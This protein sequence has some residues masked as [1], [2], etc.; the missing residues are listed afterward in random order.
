MALQIPSQKQPGPDSFPTQPDAVRDWVSTLYPLTSMD[1]CRALFRGL[2]HSNRLETDNASRVEIATILEPAIEDAIAVLREEFLDLSLPFPL[3]AA[4]AR[5]LALDLLL[6]QT[7]TYKIIVSETNNDSAQTPGPSR[8]LAIYQAL[9]T[10]SKLYECHLLSHSEPDPILLHDANTLF[11]E[12]GEDDLIDQTL[13]SEAPD[14]VTAWSILNAYVYLQL[15]SLSCPYDQR[16]RQLPTLFQFLTEHTPKLTVK[17]YKAAE[18]N[19]DSVYA[20]H[21]TQA[22]RPQRLKHTARDTDANLLTLDVAPLLAALDQVAERAPETINT[23]YEGETLSRSGLILLREALDRQKTRRVARAITRKTVHTEISL[24]HVSAAIRFTTVSEADAIPAEATQLSDSW[25][26]VPIHRK[27]RW[28]V[29]NEN[30]FGACLEWLDK[31]PTDAAVGQV[32]ALK[33]T[34]KAKV[35][36]WVTGIIRWIKSLGPAHLKIGIEF[37][38]TEASALKVELTTE[39]QTT[40]H[41]CVRTLLLTGV[42]QSDARVALITPP[43]IFR[44][45]EEI[46]TE[47]KPLLLEERLASTGGFDVFGVVDK[48]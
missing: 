38:G 41:D 1:S 30:R 23:F 29:C 39:E 27:G 8:Q 24:R 9:R 32:I 15:L 2:K 7:F 21:H 25:P 44:Q 20:I 28:I 42:F 5:Q 35:P 48:P 14:G 19:N 6:E 17:P 18:S 40:N 37:L 11:N 45:G 36:T 10:L 22:G 12:A 43:L 3:R 34:T 16:Q 4:Q 33:R 26:S 31:E 47:D 13:D 46:I